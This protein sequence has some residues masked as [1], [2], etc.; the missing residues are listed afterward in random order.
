VGIVVVDQ[1][2]AFVD[3]K[4]LDRVILARDMA[5]PAV[6]AV[7]AG[8]AIE[9]EYALA[10]LQQG[11]QHGDV[12]DGGRQR[13]NVGMLRAEQPLRRARSRGFSIASITSPP[14]KGHARRVAG[15]VLVDQHRRLGFERRARAIAFRRD[16]IDRTGVV[17]A[18]PLDQRGDLAVAC[19]RIG[20]QLAP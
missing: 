16:E 5:R 15:G 13:L 2:R 7:S 18:L 19:E 20:E 1:A 14:A 3:A 9:R 4:R 17:H 10:R 6:A 8:D 12:G 11:A